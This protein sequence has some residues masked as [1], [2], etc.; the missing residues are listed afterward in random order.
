MLFPSS[1]RRTVRA[2]RV[3]Q[4]KNEG[5]QTHLWFHAGPE[6]DYLTQYDGMTAAE[7]DQIFAGTAE[8]VYRLL[9]GSK[10]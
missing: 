8:R 6:P 1:R 5:T 9:P 10:L 7:K 4:T 2:S 3:Q